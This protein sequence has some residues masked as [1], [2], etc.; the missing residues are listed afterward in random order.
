MPSSR[1]TILHKTGTHHELIMTH[2]AVVMWP[3]PAVKEGPCFD[4]ELLQ[5]ERD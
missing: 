3:P 1:V 5:A 4:T 2:I